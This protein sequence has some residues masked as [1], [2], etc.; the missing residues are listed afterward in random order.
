VLLITPCNNSCNAHL[1][2]SHITPRLT[3]SR[4]YYIPQRICMHTYTHSSKTAYRTIQAR[5]KN[6]NKYRIFF[7]TTF[8]YGDIL[9]P[10]FYLVHPPKTVGRYIANH[11]PLLYFVL[12]CM[13]EF[14][15]RH[16]RLTIQDNSI[17]FNFTFTMVS[18]CSIVIFLYSYIVIVMFLFLFSCCGSNEV[19]PRRD[20]SCLRL[21]PLRNPVSSYCVLRIAYCVLRIAY[22]VLRIAY[23]VLRIAY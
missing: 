13:E 17:H 20:R 8:N 4:E 15:T 21:F 14:L 22:C 5:S 3:D 12:H 1:D 2:S 11:L 18:I 7:G 23:C 16:T 6:Q 19:I 10:S 9:V